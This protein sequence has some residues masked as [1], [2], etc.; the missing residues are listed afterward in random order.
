[1]RLN[2]LGAILLYYMFGFPHLPLD[3][4]DGVFQAGEMPLLATCYIT[5]ED[6]EAAVRF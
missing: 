6:A 5:G 4:V 3:I 2:G 1:M